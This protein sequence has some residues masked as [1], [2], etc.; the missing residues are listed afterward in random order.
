L[1]ITEVMIRTFPQLNVVS[2][3][4]CQPGPQIEKESLVRNYPNPVQGETTVEFKTDGGHTLLQLI[5]PNGRMISTL[6]EATYDRPTTATTKVNLRG[7]QPGM[8]YIRFQ[9]GNKSEMK[10]IIKI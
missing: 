9:N 1:S 7:M 10:P 8:Y 5:G 2:D 6:L 3:A 4:Q